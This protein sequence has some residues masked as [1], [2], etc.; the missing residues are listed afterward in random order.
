MGRTNG[1]GGS[2]QSEEGDIP[3]SEGQSGSGNGQ[4]SGEDQMGGGAPGE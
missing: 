3:Q 2:E 1:D 4:G